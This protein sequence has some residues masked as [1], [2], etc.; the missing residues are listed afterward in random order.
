VVGDLGT[1]LAGEC[2]DGDGLWAQTATPPSV[3][4][5]DATRRK[6]LLS[7][8]VGALRAVARRP[9]PRRAAE[10]GA[11]S[12]CLLTRAC[13]A[14]AHCSDDDSDMSDKSSKA[15]GDEME[16]ENRST[17]RASSPR[18]AQDASEELTESSTD[19]DDE[20]RERLER[21]KKL[22]RSEITVRQW[23]RSAV[24]CTDLHARTHAHTAKRLPK[25]KPWALAQVQILRDRPG[26]GA[27]PRARQSRA[28]LLSQVRT[29]TMPRHHVLPYLRL[30]VCI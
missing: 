13:F 19:E 10:T 29:C 20:Y 26:R 12:K 15:G 4:S 8:G 25:K 2:L 22:A 11:T 5:D 27:R 21:A 24:L 6:R 17:P 28:D 18:E 1:C 7:W 9:H 14:H 23:D 30:R 3:A 16:H